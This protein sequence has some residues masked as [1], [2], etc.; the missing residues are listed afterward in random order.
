[1]PKY[2]TPDRP[3][4]YWGKLIHPSQMPL[5]EDWKSQDWE[6]MQVFENCIDPADDEHLAVHVPGISPAQWL[7]DFVW[8]PRVEDFK[9]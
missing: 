1:M 5:T 2:P 6:V 9:S 7:P 4:H 8:G 3:G